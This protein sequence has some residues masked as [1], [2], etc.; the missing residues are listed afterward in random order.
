MSNARKA[1]AHFIKDGKKSDRN[2]SDYIKNFSFVDVASG[3]S[4]SCSASLSN[5][6]KRFLSDWL[7]SKGEVY[8]ATIELKNWEAEGKDQL[9]LAGRFVIDDFSFSGRPLT[10]SINGVATPSNSGFTT[11]ERTKTWKSITIKQIAKKIAKRYKLSLVYEAG[12]I[13]IKTLEQNKEADSSFLNSLCEDYGLAMKIFCFQLVIYSKA[14]YES[15]K[16]IATIDEKDME[17]WDY[18]TTLTGTYTGAKFSYTDPSSNKTVKVQ[19]GKGSRWLTASGEASSKDDATKRAYAAVNNS[20]EGMTTLSFTIQGNQKLTAASNIKITGLGKLNGKYF[21]T[22]I[23]HNVGS[24]GYTMDVEARLIQ[25]RLPVKTV[26]MKAKSKLTYYTKLNGKSAGSIS[27]DTKV[28]LLSKNAGTMT[29]NN[30]KCQM[31]KVK[32]NGKSVYVKYSGL[33]S[34]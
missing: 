4:D 32:Y 19:V 3:S 17:S 9:V 2:M 30:K 34:S 16:A 23:K 14:R 5:I 25:Q 20:N 26:Y 11:K 29:I 7:P 22:K 31:S 24:S 28:Q 21:I 1:V 15:K 8:R 18:S 6:D 13:K 12:D 10:C 27:K 33:K